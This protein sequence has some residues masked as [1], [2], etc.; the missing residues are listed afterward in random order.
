MNN[1][2]LFLKVKSWEGPVFMI[3]ITSNVLSSH[4]LNILIK[5]V[6]L[7]IGYNELC[8][9]CGSIF[10]LAVVSNPSTLDL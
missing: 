6:N 3:N 1:L 4:A 2:R 7:N 5:T 9:K 8:K 10:R